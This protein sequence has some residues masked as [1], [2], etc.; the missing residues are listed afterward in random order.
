MFRD[1]CDP[2]LSCRTSQPTMKDGGRFSKSPGVVRNETTLP[3][4]LQ[5][6]EDLGVDAPLSTQEDV[7]RSKPLSRI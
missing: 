2:Y 6:K 1:S 7:L 3:P 5:S 4:P